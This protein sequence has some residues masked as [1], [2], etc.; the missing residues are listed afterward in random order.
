MK[1]VGYLLDFEQNPSLS[2]F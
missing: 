1:S 2:T